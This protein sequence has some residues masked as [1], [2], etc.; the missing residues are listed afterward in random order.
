[1][2]LMAFRK[3]KSALNTSQ[4]M[5]K[6]YTH[7]F[8][9]LDNTLWNFEKNSRCAMLETFRFFK[10]NEKNDFDVFF[11]IY[12]KHNH[13]LWDSYRKKELGK[14]ELVEKRFQN[15]FEEQKISGVDALEMNTHYLNVMPKQK[16]L[17]DGVLDILNY[18][19]AKRYKMYIITNG[20]REVQTNKLESSGL[21]PYFSK[22]FISE[23][24]KVPKPGRE[25]FDYAI[26]S[27]NAQKKK[28]I[29]IGD[30]WDVDVI[31]ALHYG[32]D[33]VHFDISQSNEIKFAENPVNSSNM[34]YKCGFLGSLQA[35]L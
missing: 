19:K 20:F 6:K 5:N 22:V 23:E 8:F 27:A 10:L 4:I 11:E 32:I 3:N 12:S 15:T 16:I 7:I 26:K 25:I 33:S 2:L 29:M 31:G 17:N 21:K 34:V 1:M 35:I 30:D 13:Q 9:D 14:N 24:I 28:S 18:L